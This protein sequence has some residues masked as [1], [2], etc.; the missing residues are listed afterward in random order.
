MI[1]S[2]EDRLFDFFPS[3]RI[4]I[5]IAKVDNTRYGDDVLEPVLTRIRNDLGGRDFHFDPRISH[6]TTAFKKLGMTQKPLATSV[7]F[8][9]DR[10]LTRGIFPRINPVVDLL[11]AVSLDFLVPIGSHDISSLDGNIVLGF[12]RGDERF[13]P[14]EGGEEEIVGKG[15]VVYKDSRSALTRGWVSRQSNKDRV[16]SDTTSVFMPVDIL[17]YEAWPPVEQILDQLGVYLSDLGGTEISYRNVV[18]RKSP[19]A[20]FTI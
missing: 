17:D 6:W 19:A 9:I 16:S 5:L 20:E 7:E 13:T 1:F 2:V 11:S 15:E 10:A 4:G 18:D 12:S 14:I 8:L 3:L